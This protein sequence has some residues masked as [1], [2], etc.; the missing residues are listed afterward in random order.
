MILVRHVAILKNRKVKT[1]PSYFTNK[2]PK[3]LKGEVTVVLC[4]SGD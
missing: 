2:A 1:A 4:D 3:I